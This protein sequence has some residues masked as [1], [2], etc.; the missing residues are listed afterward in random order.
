[1]AAASPVPARVLNLLSITHSCVVCAAVAAC[2]SVLKTFIAK[3]KTRHASPGFRCIMHHQ[4]LKT[5]KN[6]NYEQ[7]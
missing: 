2:A 6:Y 3:V 4:K 7:N 1:M 5:F